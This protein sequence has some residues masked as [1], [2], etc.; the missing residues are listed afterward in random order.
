M[1]VF[2]ELPS[3]YVGF[4]ICNFSMHLEVYT[5]HFVSYVFPSTYLKMRER[6]WFGHLILVRIVE[7]VFLSH[8]YIIKYFFITVSFFL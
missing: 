1:L 8:F 4:L 3:L 7:L 5:S 2:L 6:N